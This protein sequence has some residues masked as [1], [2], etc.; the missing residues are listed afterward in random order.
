MLSKM[1]F[2]LRW[3][4]EGLQPAIQHRQKLLPKLIAHR[5]ALN[6]AIAELQGLAEVEK[7]AKPGKKTRRRRRARN[8]IGLAD[9][10]A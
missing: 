7:P 8:K 6:R 9:L 1:L 10:L 5:D 4:L 2:G 3:P